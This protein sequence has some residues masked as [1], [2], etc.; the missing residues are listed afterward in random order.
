MRLWIISGSFFISDQS[1]P[2]PCITLAILKQFTLN[3]CCR[4][5]VSARSRSSQEEMWVGF[6]YQEAGQRQVLG[7]S[8]AQV[9]H[10]DSSH[11]SSPC[12]LLNTVRAKSFCLTA[13]LYPISLVPSYAHSLFK[14]N[15]LS[16]SRNVQ[17]IPYLQIDVSL[18]NNRGTRSAEE[19]LSCCS[20]TQLLA[21][22]ICT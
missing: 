6:K 1:L 9:M 12:C 21:G 14:S 18:L 7:A 11:S 2:N 17:R 16:C 15:N 13:A 3:I 4:A 10:Q 8:A 20:V 19:T 5:G 22:Q